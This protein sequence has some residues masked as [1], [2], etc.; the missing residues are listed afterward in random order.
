MPWFSPTLRSSFAASAH[1]ITLQAVGPNDRPP[2]GFGEQ[3]T[4]SA[5]PRPLWER[6]LVVR[7]GHAADPIPPSRQV[8]L[9]PVLL[10]TCLLAI[11]I[12]VCSTSPVI[13]VSAVT[14]QALGYDLLAEVSA[15]HFH[16][17]AL[18]VQA[19]LDE[20]DYWVNYMD[21]WLRHREGD[22]S[23]A[24][25]EPDLKRVMLPWMAGVAN[26]VGGMC[27]IF[28]REYVPGKKWSFCASRMDFAGRR[29][30]FWEHFTNSTVMYRDHVDRYWNLGATLETWDAPSDRGER[31]FNMSDGSA[32]WLEPWLWQEDRPDGSAPAFTEVGQYRMTRVDG[33]PVIH[34]VWMQDVDWAALLHS[35]VQFFSGG[36]AGASTA[37]L[38]DDRGTL[39]AA[40]CGATHRAGQLVAAAGSDCAVVA[41][42]Y[43]A[44]APLAAPPEAQATAASV[45]TA[46]GSFLISWQRIVTSRGDVT[47][48]YLV[49][50][51]PHSS[52]D[53][54]IRWSVVLLV[55][56]SVTSLAAVALVAVLFTNKMIASPL[57]Q[58]AWD[59]HRCVELDVV[60]S[61]V[62]RGT[63]V[64]ELSL[65][66][67]SF[68][69]MRVMLD[70]VTRFLPVEVLQPCLKSGTPVGFSMVP[71]AATVFFLD[72]ENFTNLTESTDAAQLV[73]SIG[74]F[75]EE[76]S[77]II[78]RRRGV[79]DKYIGK[80]R[81]SGRQ[82]PGPSPA[83]DCVMAFWNAPSPVKDHEYHACR[84]ALECA[85]WMVHRQ[86]GSLRLSGRMGLE[87]GQVHAGIF[88]SRH[89][90]NYTVVGD[91]VN[92]ASRLEGLNKERKTRILIGP[93]LH[94]AV[95]RRVVTRR[96]DGV[97]LK[98]KAMGMSVYELLR[99]VDP[100]GPEVASSGPDT[101][102]TWHTP[103]GVT[104]APEED[105]E[106]EEEDGVDAVRPC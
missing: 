6:C 64:R 84:A 50:A 41:Q 48:Y 75:F 42:T 96:L 78:V 35:V 100:D 79:I 70:T 95:E 66:M 25:M 20:A 22:L 55:I 9:I 11:F 90:M 52:V 72:I 47:P 5:P 86:G 92:V 99:L 3:L 74:A 32:E 105:E 54:P 63:C 58:V 31:Y 39:I 65:M 89:R 56:I 67:E 80:T 14:T 106:E 85:D 87:A 24:V 10:L 46:T 94:A 81:I 103:G 15:Q 82:S 77:S 16:V 38:V 18:R 7:S 62:P 23:G 69:K 30:L 33:L 91:V 60:G 28:P 51:T 93:Q 26:R 19:A 59:M 40:T 27:T 8:P 29:D 45:A 83:G 53:G 61:A 13:A 37:Y 2:P 12:S 73:E 104:T 36:A 4:L 44:L 76:L 98:G 71:T 34:F 57:R 97:Y 68:A 102:M 1:A 17:L 43:Q 21:A 88:G 49:L 101:V